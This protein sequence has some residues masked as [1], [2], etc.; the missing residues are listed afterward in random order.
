MKTS[1][2]IT[3]L[4]FM[5]LVAAILF[6]CSPAATITVTFGTTNSI[7]ALSTVTNVPET[8]SEAI[9]GLSDYI[10]STITNLYGN[11]LSLSF[12]S[13][14]GSLSPVGNSFPTNLAD[15][16]FTQYTILTE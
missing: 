8:R 10:I 6:E 11:L 3:I 9:G 4:L 15:N 16:A 7:P 2:Q 12:G 5:A 1:H 13:D 14:V